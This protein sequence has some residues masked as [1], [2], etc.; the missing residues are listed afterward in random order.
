MEKGKGQNSKLCFADI[1]D[2]IAGLEDFSPK[3]YEK[4]MAA[5]NKASIELVD[6]LSKEDLE[7]ANA[8]P[9]KEKKSATRT[10]PVQAA[11]VKATAKPAEKNNPEK[12]T[13]VPTSTLAGPNM[14]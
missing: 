14:E 11:P 5:V 3:D 1:T 7:A 8:K 4:V 6:K 12:D 13:A 2:M 9:K 10:A